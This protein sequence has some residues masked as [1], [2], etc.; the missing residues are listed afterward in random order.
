MVERR[1]QE[2]G[3]YIVD[4]GIYFPWT[5]ATCHQSPSEEL[6]DPE[7]RDSGPDLVSSYSSD[8]SP[9]L[10]FGPG[11]LEQHSAHCYPKSCYQK[12]VR[13]VPSY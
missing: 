1:V 8:V 12:R 10:A 11:S 13:L 2:T 9:A 6:S 5:L 4:V 3:K 7:A